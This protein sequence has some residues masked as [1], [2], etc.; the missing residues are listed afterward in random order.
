MIAD[1]V[2]AVIQMTELQS[3]AH[4][5]AII[6]GFK[7]KVTGMDRVNSYTW[8]F[9]FVDNSYIQITFTGTSRVDFELGTV[10]PLGSQ[11]TTNKPH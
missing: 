4:L 8:R 10:L 2:N 11:T 1:E 9:Y 6:R 5:A 7:D 3:I